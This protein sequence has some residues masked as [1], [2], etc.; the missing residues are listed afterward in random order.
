MKRM[1]LQII[2]KSTLQIWYVISITLYFQS[3]F[4]ECRLFW[5][6]SNYHLKCRIK[7]II[8]FFMLIL[9]TNKVG[10]VY[11]NTNK[12][13]NKLQ[14]CGRVKSPFQHASTVC[15]KY[16]ERVSR[17]SGL[18]MQISPAVGKFSHSC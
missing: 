15:T 17:L 14:G 11:L 1:I 13:R 10:F 8:A 4:Q 5:F 16:K 3:F 7:K 9:R 12:Y 6:I 18:G 2:I